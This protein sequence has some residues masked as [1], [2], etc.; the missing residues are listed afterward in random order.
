MLAF[1]LWV[2]SHKGLFI[3]LC[4]ILFFVV[5]IVYANV[6]TGGETSLTH[7]D[8][9]GNITSETGEDEEETDTSIKE[10]EEEDNLFGII[11]DDGTD[12]FLINAQD[13]LIEKF[14]RPPEGFIWDYD[15]T[16]LS[17]GDPNLTSE[18]V[19]YSFIRAL[20]LLDFGS[21]QKYS[22][23]SSVVETY[24]EY[25]DSNLSDVFDYKDQFDRNMYK[26][27]IMSL[28]VEGITD[29]AVFAENKRVYTVKASMIDLTDK[30]FWQ[31]DKDTLFDELYKYNKIEDDDTKL[32]LRL[33]DYILGY[34]QSPDPVR[35]DVTF[36]I[37]V[38]RYPD[39]NSGWLVSIDKDIDLN[40]Q[41]SD[42]VAV[43]A[44][45]KE[46]FNEYSLNRSLQEQEEARN[47]QQLQREQ[48]QANKE[49]E[50][51]AALEAAENSEDSED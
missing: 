27:A 7:S 47:L 10:E 15:G 30:D 42:G 14:G 32:D 21:A 2:G 40:C 34:Y 29:S 22:R 45:I 39:L 13:N 1:R 3:A 17:I 44:Y 41:Y 5:M 28:Q 46:L 9:D 25:F 48:E 4:I 50:V 19:V 33:Y 12:E 11:V 8:E 23:G 43:L 49:A 26:E 51:A 18:E 31:Q 6:S 35:R 37:T 24:A 16:T 36:D 20:A 38:E